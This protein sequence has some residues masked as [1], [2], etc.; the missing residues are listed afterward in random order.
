MLLSRSNN[1]SDIRLLCTSLVDL[2]WLFPFARHQHGISRPTKHDFTFLSPSALYRTALHYHL[3][4][5]TNTTIS[6]G[7]HPMLP[8][9]TNSVESPASSNRLFPG[10]PLVQHNDAT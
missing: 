4:S 7:L 2:I 3:A 1:S 9:C 8:T 6:Y 10:V 5:H